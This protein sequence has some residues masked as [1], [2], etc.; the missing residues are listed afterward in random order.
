MGSFRNTVLVAGLTLQGCDVFEGANPNLAPT[1]DS[2]MVE[3][4]EGLNE[5]SLD[6]VFVL[7]GLST[8]KVYASVRGTRQQ[9]EEA[10]LT[11]LAN[12]AMSAPITLEAP[13]GEEGEVSI[14]VEIRNMTV[15]TGTEVGVCLIGNSKVFDCAQVL[16]PDGINETPDLEPSK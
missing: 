3:D 15:F 4:S 14:T 9:L 5:P 16:I 12:G 7:Q 1:E 13:E 2:E 11:V 8:D 6:E 10:F